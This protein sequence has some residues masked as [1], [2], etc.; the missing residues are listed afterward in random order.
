MTIEKLTEQFGID[1]VVEFCLG[2]GGLK[3]VKV[4]ASSGSAE[5]Y[6][7]G[8]HLSQWTPTGQEP[9]IWLSESSWFEAGKPIRGGVPICFPWFGPKA[10]SPDSPNHGFARLLEWTVESVAQNDDGS[11]TLGLL[12]DSS[13]DGVREYEKFWPGCCEGGFELRAVFTIGSELTIELELRNTGGVAFSISEAL[14]T[15]LKTSDVRNVSVAGLAGAEYVSKDEGIRQAQADEL[16]HFTSETDRVYI[17]TQ[18]T[19][20]L[21]DPD[22]GREIVVSKS[23]SDSTVIWNPWSAKAAAMPDFGDN[24]WLGM[25][26]IETANALDNTIDVQPGKSHTIRMQLAVA[27]K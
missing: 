18:S 3:C 23:G 8:A 19:C 13:S 17:N 10:D 14:H 25:V 7:Q 4:S 27:Q 22:L 26:C 11:V 20:V 9:V 21:A 1:G 12:L 6:L 24:E 5:V 15:Y 2:R 16:I